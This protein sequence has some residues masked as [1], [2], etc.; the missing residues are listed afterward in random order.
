VFGLVLL[1][2]PDPD[3][4]IKNKG[5]SNKD[6]NNEKDVSASDTSVQDMLLLSIKEH[7]D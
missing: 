5:S 7:C 2:Y 4:Y 3:S 6:M 1:I